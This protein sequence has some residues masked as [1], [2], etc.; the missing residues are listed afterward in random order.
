MQAIVLA[1]G[2]FVRTFLEKK[3]SCTVEIKRIKMTDKIIAIF[4]ARQK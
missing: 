3:P 2:Y 4:L 1:I